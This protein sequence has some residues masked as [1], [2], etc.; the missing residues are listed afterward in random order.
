MVVAG[1]GEMRFGTVKSSSVGIKIRPNVRF[2]WILSP[3]LFCVMYFRLFVK[4]SILIFMIHCFPFVMI[5]GTV[6]SG[7]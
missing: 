5:D 3:W 2:L 4:I 7:V 1:V 6:G